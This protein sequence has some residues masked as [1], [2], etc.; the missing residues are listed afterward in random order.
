MEQKT[1]PPQAD[2]RQGERPPKLTR[3]K[4]V[5]HLGVLAAGAAT[6]GLGSTTEPAMA[7]PNILEP[8]LN[9]MPA[10]KVQSRVKQE[11]LEGKEK[12]QVLGDFKRFLG[13]F[14]SEG[15]IQAMRNKNWIDD[16]SL[17][18]RRETGADFENV[19]LY[20]P[21]R[22]AESV[23]T[24]SKGT[25]NTEGEKGVIKLASIYTEHAGNDQMDNFRDDVR[26]LMNNR[27]LQ[28]VEHKISFDG[29]GDSSDVYSLNYSV[30]VPVA[31]S[32]VKDPEINQHSMISQN[33]FLKNEGLLELN[34]IITHIRPS[35]DN[36][37]I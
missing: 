23:Y 26:S 15:G 29:D 24:I 34:Q 22:P 28:F 19:V 11:I 37:P 36:T 12:D 35:L 9:I 14:F 4:F 13:G 30:E 7:A 2:A 33:M 20:Y 18:A 3:R 21:E 6:L 10:E 31:N 1:A 27:D 5:S 32:A 17:L 25:I 8:N 16:A